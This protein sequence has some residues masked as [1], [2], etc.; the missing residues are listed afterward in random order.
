MVI[1]ALPAGFGGVRGAF[2]VPP[3]DG[4][5]CA[6]YAA[7]NTRIFKWPLKGLH[8]LHINYSKSRKVS[9]L[10][11]TAGPCYSR[12]PY[13]WVFLPAQI[14]FLPPNQYFCCSWA[15]LQ[16]CRLAKKFELLE[17]MLYLLVSALDLNKQPFCCG[18]TLFAFL[19]FPSLISL[20]KCPQASCPSPVCVS[21]CK[22]A[23][24]A[25]W[26]NCMYQA[27]VA[28]PWAVSTVW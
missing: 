3:T 11:N 13:L 22:K 17:A 2:A 9:K 19:S 26:R 4:H 27:G 6:L 18:N 28:G 12:V 24:G 14:C 23:W 1:G 5:L 7:Q 25:F 15:H 20:F 8:R 10:P 16:M 21:E